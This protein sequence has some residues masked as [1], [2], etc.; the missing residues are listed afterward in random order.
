MPFCALTRHVSGPMSGA[1][2]GA[3]AVRLCALSVNSTTS[4]AP[5]AAGSSVAAGRASNAPSDPRIRTPNSCSARR[6]APRAISVTSSPNFASIAP[7]NA[8]MAPAPTTANFIATTA[9]SAA[10]FEPFVETQSVS[11]FG[12]EHL[13]AYPQAVISNHRADQTEGDGYS[14]YNHAPATAPIGYTISHNR[15]HFTMSSTGILNIMTSST[16]V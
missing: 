13:S 7:T 10:N 2:R 1:S 11:V 3:I 6:C 14:L 15:I 5:T 12:P 8:P 4:T 16:L 9:N